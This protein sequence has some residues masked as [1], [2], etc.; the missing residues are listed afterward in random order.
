[1][2]SL[3]E[4]GIKIFL[5]SVLILLGS[6]SNSFVQVFETASINI[7][8]NEKYFTY[9]T[10]T[11][12]IT[13]SFWESKGVLSFAV[14]N[15]LDKPIFIDWKN[16]SFIYNDNKLNYWID[17]SQSTGSGYYHGYFYHGPSIQPGITVMEGIQNSSISTYKPEKIT[18]IPPR[19][20]YYRSQFYLWPIESF[21]MKF[22]CQTNEVK[23][24]DNPKKMTIIYSEDFFYDNSPLRFRNYLA[25]SVTED[26]KDYFYVDNQFYIK[27]IEEVDLRHYRGK[28]IGYTKNQLLLYGKS[29]YEKSSS[30]YLTIP[31]NAS[32]ESR[33]K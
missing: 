6:C 25:F 14:Y 16:S 15:K 19:S 20:N 2:N 31:D 27:T 17:E 7:P 30:F 24:N 18:F 12:K 13:Y 28:S 29:P 21:K 1:M 9:E 33:L 11:L 10:D 23:R 26:S 32:V 5:F 3:I 4:N 22:N 8:Y